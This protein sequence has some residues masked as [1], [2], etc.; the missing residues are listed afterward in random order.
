MRLVFSG[1]LS[2]NRLFIGEQSITGRKIAIGDIIGVSALAQG[3]EEVASFFGNHHSN[4]VNKFA[5]CDYRMADNAILIN[6]SKMQM[7]CMVIDILHLKGIEEDNFVYAK[8]IEFT[9][10]KTKSFLTMEDFDNKSL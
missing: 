3:Q 10:D 1:R 4:A 5:H 7:K 6:G 9:E 2:R 8:V